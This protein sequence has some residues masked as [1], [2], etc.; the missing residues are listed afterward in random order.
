MA[1]QTKDA[2]RRG[3]STEKHGSF[4]SRTNGGNSPVTAHEDKR[5]EV[6][7]GKVTN[8]SK[9]AERVTEEQR[10][11]LQ[12]KN[13]QPL[14]KCG[15]NVNENGVERHGQKKAARIEGQKERCEKL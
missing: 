12:G 9:K 14:R 6:S 1:M 11:D 13:E 10:Y 2:G 8:N 4:E 7:Q 3:P 5:S 15:G